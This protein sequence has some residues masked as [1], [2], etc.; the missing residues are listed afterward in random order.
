MWFMSSGWYDG[1]IGMLV[2]RIDI[3]VMLVLGYQSP[4]LLC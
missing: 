3:S 4:C 1:L 2:V